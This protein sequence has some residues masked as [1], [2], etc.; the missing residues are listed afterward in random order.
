V[1]ISYFPAG[2]EAHL[3]LAEPTSTK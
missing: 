1:C 3:S 2:K